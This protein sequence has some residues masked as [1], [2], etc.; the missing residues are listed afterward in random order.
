MLGGVW[1]SS[2]S[3]TVCV[4]YSSTCGGGGGAQCRRESVV[5]YSVVRVATTPSANATRVDQVLMLEGD[6]RYRRESVAA[7]TLSMFA[8]S[9]EGDAQYQ[10]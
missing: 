3:P 5:A 7:F 1:R 8:P 6:A 2:T 10:R 9:L 4:R